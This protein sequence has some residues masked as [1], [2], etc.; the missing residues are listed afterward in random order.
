M[1]VR[2]LVVVSAIVVAF[3]LAALASAFWAAN[4]TPSDPGVLTVD[5]RQLRVGAVDEIA[6]STPKTNPP[7]ARVFVVREH[8]NAVVAFLARSTLEGCRLLKVDRPH[9][10]PY[11]PGVDFEDPCHGSL[12]TL[13]GRCIG[14]PCPRALDHYA[15]R[16]AGNHATIN[17]TQLIAGSPR[18][19]S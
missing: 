13:T 10:Q 9:Y 4:S 8:N 17:L 7:N 6:T 2:L 1:R 5:I 15:V 3:G 16:V 14:G 19:A 12:Y 11:I 18:Q